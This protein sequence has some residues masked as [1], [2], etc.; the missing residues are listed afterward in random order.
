[1]EIRHQGFSQCHTWRVHAPSSRVGH[2]KGRGFGGVV[3]KGV[4]E[5]RIGAPTIHELAASQP[6]T[7]RV[8]RTIVGVALRA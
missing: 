7:L 5:G 3:L 1:M 2:M 8:P 6:S 4:V